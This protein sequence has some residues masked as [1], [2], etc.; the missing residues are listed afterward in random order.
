M[1]VTIISFSISYLEKTNITALIICQP[2][3]RLYYENKKAFEENSKESS[4]KRSDRTERVVQASA[5]LGLIHENSV[6]RFCIFR[7]HN[8]DERGVLCVNTQ[9]FCKLPPKY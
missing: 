9:G 8:A 7:L 4:R 2:Y 3:A 5:E 1:A 6:E